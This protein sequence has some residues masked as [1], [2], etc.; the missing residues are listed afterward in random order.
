MAVDKG[1]PGG[2]QK[3]SVGTSA[4]AMDLT[5]LAGRTVSIWSDDQ[6]L[7]FSF[8]E[9]DAS[10]SLVTSGDLAAST[11]AP[12]AKRV[13]KGYAVKRVVSLRYPF[14]IAAHVTGTGTVHVGVVSD[15]DGSQ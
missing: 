8:A 3:A 14:L 2:A 7:Y 1:L 11:T 15:V 12:K 13:A 5:V 4:V 6:D 10:P 9:T